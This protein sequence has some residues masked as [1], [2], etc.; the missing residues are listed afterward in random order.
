ML[1]FWY[2]GFGCYLIKY[3][4]PSLSV[5]VTFRINL[6]LRIP[7]TKILG[8]NLS[9]F[10]VFP[11]FL[12]SNESKQQIPSR[13]ITRAI[14]IELQGCQKLLKEL[15]LNYLWE[16]I[17]LL[18]I[19]SSHLNQIIAFLSLRIRRCRILLLVLSGSDLRV[20]RIRN[21]FSTCFNLNPKPKLCFYSF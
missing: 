7:K 21:C 4:F 1:F 8:I 3:L 13:R 9:L 18:F 14:F 11:R 19:F 6:D 20:H 12:A 15:L 10:A 2:L 16:E 5:G 17:K